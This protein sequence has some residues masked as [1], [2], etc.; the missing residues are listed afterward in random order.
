MSYWFHRNP[1]KATSLQ[2]F[3]IKMFAHDPEALKIMGD[4]KQS[5]ARILELLPDPNHTSEQI[6]TALKLYLTLARGLLLQPGEG[7]AASKL[8]HALTFRWSDSVIEG[9]SVREDAVFE[10]A[11]VIINAAFWFMKHAVLIAVRPEVSMEDAKEVHSSLRRAAGLIKFVQSNLLSQLAEKAADGGDLDGRVVAAYLN[12][13]TAEA[14]EVTIARA[15]ELKHNPGLISA[16]SYETSK[17][18]TTAADSLNTLDVKVFGHWKSYFGLK[19]KFYLAYAYNYQGES[20]L[21]VDK[22]GEAIRSLQESKAMYENA[23]LLATEYAKIK[24]RG[25][26]AKPERHTFFKRLLPILNRTLEKCERENGFIYHQ[27]VPYDPV[28]LEMND[29]THG[30]VAPEDFEIPPVA[31]LWTP[32]AYAAFDESKLTKEDKDKTKSKSKSEKKAEEEVK[33]VKEVPIPD[34]ETK[35]NNESGCVIQ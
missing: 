3:E 28:E 6:N 10:V 31:P 24:G 4:L 30:L 33:P 25:T 9:V 13:C 7:V 16:L 22:C 35:H 14:Q 26:Q 15:I 27:K 17:M 32:M 34:N 18:F 20:L 23:A 29:A 2:N 21:A 8:C 5:R 12:Q 19:A 11:S 1:L